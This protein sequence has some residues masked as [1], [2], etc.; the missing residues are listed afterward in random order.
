MSKVTKKWVKDRMYKA[1][2][3]ATNSAIV[4]E[5]TL[6]VTQRQIQQLLSQVEALKGGLGLHANKI[7]A[8]E[9]SLEE[10]SP[11]KVTK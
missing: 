8:V 5:K 7:A 9:K 10:L 3:R 2:A 11:K 1:Y 6:D 4:T